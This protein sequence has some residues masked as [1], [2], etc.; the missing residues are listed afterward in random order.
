MTA[1]ENAIV[2]GVSLV[3]AVVVGVHLTLAGFD[4]VRI[5]IGSIIAF[6]VIGGAVCN[7][8]DTTR[9]WYHR[10]GQTAKDHLSFITLH[11]LHIA[12]VAWLFR[13]APFDL[14]FMII[15]GGWLMISAFILVNTSELLKSP[16]AAT[17][18]V[19]ASL[20]IIYMIGPT[21]GLEWFELLLFLKLLIGHAVP[22]SRA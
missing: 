22:L 15:M 13:G 20:L 7:M 17:L 19:V 21:P 9:R 1:G 5:L 4:W 8:T 6:D 14:S 16:M 10:A 3:S 12:L 18:Y 11:L 2:I